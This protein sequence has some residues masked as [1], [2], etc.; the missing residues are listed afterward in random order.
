MS[1]PVLI[2]FWVPAMPVAQPRHRN[3]TLPSGKQIRV[4]APKN[5]PVHHFRAC[6]VHECKQLHD[7]PP[8]V[9]AVALRI[10]YVFPRTSAMQWKTKPRRREWKVS[11]PDLDNLEKAV[12]DALNTIT[13]GDDCQI[14]LKQTAKIIA[15]GIDTPGALIEVEQLPNTVAIPWLD[16]DES[17]PITEVVCNS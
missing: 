6:T 7:L 11:K 3:F 2:R 17:R 4:G 15:A 13:Y 9:G 16:L 12:M 8:I 5:H 14:A 10:V 1:Q